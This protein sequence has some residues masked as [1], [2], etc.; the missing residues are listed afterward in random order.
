MKTILTP[1]VKKQ[2]LDAAKSAKYEGNDFVYLDSDR[3]ISI[4]CDGLTPE[5]YAEL[6]FEEI[7]DLLFGHADSILKTL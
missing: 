4:Y 6:D 1:A 3:I 5:E 2:I 7:E